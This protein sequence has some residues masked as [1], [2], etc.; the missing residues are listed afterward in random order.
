MSRNHEQVAGDGSLRTPRRSASCTALSSEPA[1]CRCVH[2][3]AQVV[4]LTQRAVQR[5]QERELIGALYTLRYNTELE[6][7]RKRND[8]S[9]DLP[10]TGVFFGALHE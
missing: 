6:I 7:T 5:P 3:F 1:G 4:P 10:V 2:R 8:R 9:D